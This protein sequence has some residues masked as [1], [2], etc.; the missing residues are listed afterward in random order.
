MSPFCL[1]TCSQWLQRGS[2]REKPVLNIQQGGVRQ[3]KSKLRATHCYLMVRKWNERFL[4][5]L[6]C[7]FYVK[8]HIQWKFPTM[9]LSVWPYSC[10]TANPLWG[11]HGHYWGSGK[12]SGVFPEVLLFSLPESAEFPWGEALFLTH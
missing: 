4:N 11:V 7:V 6:L 9:Y 8:C 2:I 1:L 5:P 3:S 12:L 10:L